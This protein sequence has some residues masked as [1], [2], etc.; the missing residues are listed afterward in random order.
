MQ[1]DSLFKMFLKGEVAKRVYDS[2][3]TAIG[4]ANSYFTITYLTV[5]EFGLFQ[6]LLAFVAILDSLNLDIFDGMVT[7]DMRKYVNEKKPDFAK[8]LFWENA[9]L[10]IGISFFM[11]VAVF[12]G[13]GIIANLYGENIALFVKITS[14]LLLARAVFA[15]EA[16]FLKSVMNFSHWSFPTLREFSKFLM[17]VGVI[18]FAK[19]NI[20]AIVI[21]H[22]TAEAL[23]VVMLTVFVFLRVYRR[24]T[25]AIK[26]V[27]Q[28]LLWNLLKVHGKWTAIRYAFSRITKNAMPWFVKFFTNTEGVAYYSLAINIIAFAENLM[29]M[30]G[31]STILL[32]K[33]GIRE[34]I[35]FIFKR[36]M[37]Y[38]FWLGVIFMVGGLIILP[39]VVL[40]I[41]PKYGPALPVLS[42]M[43]LA[44]PLYGVYKVLKP[45]LTIL[46]EYKI[47]ALRVVREALVIPV[48]AVIFLPLLG[49]LGAGIVYNA[50][51]WERVPYLYRK[52]T[53]KYPDFKLKLS[54]LFRFDATDYEILKKSWR[55]ILEKIRQ[56]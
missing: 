41:F 18:F 53:E 35:A 16:G 54:G 36:S 47:M 55:G 21:A 12:L 44:F 25:A 39:P 6:L 3:A 2:M 8:K 4:F 48:G 1:K 32:M 13:S 52:L 30:A 11:A 5:F 10:K 28:P 26:A 19:L 23:A 20:M 45:T 33:A 34:E 29:P 7:V 40:F 22:V 51:Y 46:Q 14:I 37:K 56:K 17:I 24:Q 42:V 9:I 27:K 38:M 50:V 31:V 43:L 15:I 49:V